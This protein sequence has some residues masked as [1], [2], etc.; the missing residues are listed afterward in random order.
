VKVTQGSLATWIEQLEHELENAAS[1][2]AAARAMREAA[3][4]GLDLSPAVDVLTRAINE[5]SQVSVLEVAADALTVHLLRIGA[6]EQ[7]LD[8]AASL[9]HGS[10][11]SAALVRS[12]SHGRDLSAVVRLLCAKPGRRP[13]K[14]DALPLLN[15]AIGRDPRRLAEVTALLVEHNRPLLMRLFREHLLPRSGLD[16]SGV[17][18]TLVRLLEEGDPTITR[19]APWLLYLATDASMDLSRAFTSLEGLLTS[20]DQETRQRA[21]YSL[22]SAQLRLGAW[23]EVARLGRHAD[24]LVRAEVGRSLCGTLNSNLP[25]AAQAFGPLCLALSDRDATV[26]TLAAEGLSSA[27]RHGRPLAPP[28]EAMDALVAGLRDPVVAAGVAE[29]LALVSLQQPDSLA[30]WRAAIVE[31]CAAAAGVSLQRLHRVCTTTDPTEPPCERCLRLPRQ[32]RWTSEGEAPLGLSE[33][34]K[35]G[36]LW[37]CPTCHSIYRRGYS[38]E[39][40]DMSLSQEWSLERLSPTAARAALQGPEKARLEAHLEL[41]LRTAE[42]R[43][44]HPLRGVR[45]EAARVL[46]E[47]LG[48]ARDVEQLRK[49][50]RHPD[51][52][53]RA[54]LATSLEEQHRASPGWVISQE[55]LSELLVDPSP[56]VKRS[57]AMLWTRQAHGHGAMAQVRALLGSEDAVVVA[58]TICELRRAG[59]GGVAVA[60]FVGELLVLAGAGDAEVRKA[61][62]WALGDVVKTAAQGQALVKTYLHQAAKTGSAHVD[63]RNEAADHLAALGAQGVDL[64]LAMPTLARLLANPK[65]AWHANAAVKAALSQST[66]LGPALEAVVRG[67]SRKVMEREVDFA[68]TLELVA[69]KQPA[70]LRDALPVIARCLST[71]SEARRATLVRVLQALHAGAVDLSGV[72]AVLERALPKL[73]GYQ[74]EA[75]VPLLV[76]GW[77]ARREWS[78][79]KRLLHRRLRAT[80]WC[81]CEAARLAGQHGLDLTPIVVDLVGLLESRNEY[82]RGYPLKVLE[83]HFARTQAGAGQVVAALRTVRQSPERDR[84][85][86]RLAPVNS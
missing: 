81:V 76:K 82:G 31:A 77:L 47:H 68:E 27:H 84:L 6:V 17:L 3:R 38:S 43:L 10:Y 55:L 70:A 45:E 15:A 44:E 34:V 22:A 21:A 5:A 60:P 86:A 29:F 11:V 64:G 78:R 24:A 12:A 49:L 35:E 33:L 85:L 40:E 62:G 9:R 65:T 71:A 18:P 30:P 41:L 7:L 66:S 19:E 4:G 79:I 75:L 69:Q 59:G 53:V 56:L 73:E 36:A 1:Q 58:E 2:S 83:E 46:A 48:A 39:Y 54:T 52:A 16:V 51:E 42:R 25:M 50:L 32:A 61:V 23:A 28:P 14:L 67:L 80:G 63:L 72:D 26:R 8:L 20:K 74:R 13:R 57:A 37:R